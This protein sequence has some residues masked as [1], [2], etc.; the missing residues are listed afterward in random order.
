MKDNIIFIHIRV[1]INRTIEYLQ[2][3]YLFISTLLWHI[4]S[5]FFSSENVDAVAKFIFLQSDG[6]TKGMSPRVYKRFIGLNLVDQEHKVIDQ[7]VNFNDPP[8]E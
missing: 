1:S 4:F 6:E 7:L 3:K 2:L 8:R 5:Y